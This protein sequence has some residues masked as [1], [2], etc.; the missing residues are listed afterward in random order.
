MSTNAT[1]GQALTSQQ[2]AALGLPQDDLIYWYP[3]NVVLTALQAGVVATL[4]ILNDADFE[5]RWII[6][7]Q[8]GLWQATLIDQLRS[9]PL[10]SSDINSENLAG[11]AQ[12]PF[13]LPKP[14]NLLRTSTVKGTF[15]DRS[16]SGNTIQLC[17]VGY[18]LNL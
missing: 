11:T 6:S 2:K 18:K 16:G 8:T 9:R 17:L 14:W 3:L 1:A 10:M 13:I 4:Q 7:S 15:T 5:C 12:L